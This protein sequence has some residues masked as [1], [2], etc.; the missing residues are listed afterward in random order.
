MCLLLG[1]VCV[2][3]AKLV[4]VFSLGYLPSKKRAGGEKKRER[5]RDRGEER[6]KMKKERSRRKTY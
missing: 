5:N 3:C 4:V 6:E 1:C 2:N